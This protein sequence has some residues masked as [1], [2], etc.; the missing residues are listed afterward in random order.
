MFCSQSNGDDYMFKFNDIMIPT[1]FSKY[2]NISLNY[3]KDM[4]K[5]TGSTLHIVH[6][7]ETTLIPSTFDLS[8]HMRLVDVKDEV[9]KQSRKKLDEIMDNL[10]K[11]DF[12]VKTKLLHGSAASEIVDYAKEH[13]I[14]SI[15][16]ATQGTS[17]IEH[18]LFGSTTEKVLRTAPCPVV[19]I[20]IPEYFNNS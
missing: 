3:A 5:S 6:V 1:D 11:E 8:S 20:R 12:A 7:V 13:K 16:I 10:L 15:C 2:F 18:F 17:G 14:D 9:D 4:A 19:A